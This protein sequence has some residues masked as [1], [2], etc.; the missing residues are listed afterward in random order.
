MKE[1][2]Y[3]QIENDMPEINDERLVSSKT[4]LLIVEWYM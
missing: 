2:N 4:Y 3:L 1:K